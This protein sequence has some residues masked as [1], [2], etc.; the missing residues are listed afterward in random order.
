MGYSNSSHFL[1]FVPPGTLPFG[2]FS[3]GLNGKT[4]VHKLFC[5]ISGTTKVCC[6]EIR[7]KSLAF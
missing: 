1:S 3:G 5:H 6:W 7:L 2:K 4:N